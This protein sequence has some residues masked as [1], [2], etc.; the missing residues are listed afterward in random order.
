MRLYGPHRIWSSKPVFTLA[1]AQSQVWRCQ[2]NVWNLFKANNKDTRTSSTTL[3]WC[4]YWQFWTGFTCSSGVSMTDFEQVHTGWLIYF[5]LYRLTLARAL[6]YP[7]FHFLSYNTGIGW[8]ASLS[9]FLYLS[10]MSSKIIGKTQ[11]AILQ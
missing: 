1:K 2:N 9:I 4:L 3:F 11:G 8:K 6:V 10:I 5:W 7:R